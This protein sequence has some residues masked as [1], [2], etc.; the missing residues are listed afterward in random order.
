MS[1]PF[2]D[3]DELRKHFLN[4][5]NFLK[6]HEKKRWEESLLHKLFAEPA[7]KE[8][9]RLSCFVSFGSELN[10]LPIM[11]ECRYEQ[12]KLFVPRVISRTEGMEMVE[13]EDEDELVPGQYGLS[14]PAAFLEG[15]RTPELD[16][17]IVPGLVFDKN[18]YRIGYGGGFYDR[19]LVHY[20]TVHKIALAYPYQLV[21]ALP[22]DEDDVPVSNVIT[23]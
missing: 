19:F 18:G 15:E 20:P 21:D 5:R 13:I 22:H 12:K 17:I 16:L 6:P 4:T 7:F 23:P 1:L 3:K 8:A 11:H 14:E 9:K 2:Q 10:T